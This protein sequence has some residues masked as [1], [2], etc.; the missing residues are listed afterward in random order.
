M[1]TRHLRSVAV[2]AAALSLS[3]WKALASDPA[4]SGGSGSSHKT[5]IVVHASS[6]AVGV[7]AEDAYL[8]KHYP[9]YRFIRRAF[10]FYQSKSYDIITF[11]DAHGKKHSLYFDISEYFKPK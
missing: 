5:A 1:L 10:A 8:R 7:R 2:L 3:A 11:I 6:A 4:I 9:G